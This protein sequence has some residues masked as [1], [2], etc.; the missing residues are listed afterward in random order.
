MTQRE[1][2]FRAWKE[3]MLTGFVI[4]GT[5]QIAYT[6]LN[7]IKTVVNDCVLMQYT[8][9][10]DKNGRE[11]YEGDI[12]INGLSGTWLIQPLEN[13]SMSLLGVCEKYKDR[14]FDISALNSNVLIIGNLYENP[15]LI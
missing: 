1:I 11:I 7:E 14:N 4:L 2:K 12:V 6:H 9:L 15:K 10:K 3:K 13:G 5:N 8:G